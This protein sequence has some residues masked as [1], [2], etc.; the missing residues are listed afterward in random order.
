MIILKQ[1]KYG[2]NVIPAYVWHD[3]H[4]TVIEILGGRH[5]IS[6]QNFCEKVSEEYVLNK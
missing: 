6:K 1:G 4:C 2:F 5:S 3:K